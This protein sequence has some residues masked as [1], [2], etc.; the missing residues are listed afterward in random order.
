M[1][2]ILKYGYQGQ[3]TKISEARDQPYKWSIFEC[4]LE[5]IK[6]KYDLTTIQTA[7]NE[8]QNNQV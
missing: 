8:L 7:V 1:N 4:E 6:L 5:L 3:P 2:T